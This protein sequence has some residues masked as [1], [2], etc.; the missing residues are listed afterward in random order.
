MALTNL[1]A[2]ANPYG[3]SSDSQD[4]GSKEIECCICINAIGPFQALFISPCSHI[5]HHKCVS[6]MINKSPM[7]QCPLCRQVANLTASISSGSLINLAEALPVM[8]KLHTEIPTA[9][10][11]A[12]AL[13]PVAES[14]RR[15][16]SSMVAQRLSLMSAFFRRPSS[17]NAGSATTPEAT[18][19]GIPRF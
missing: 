3:G 9:T 6:S 8:G 11:L 5:Y 1:L 16:S 12:N 18:P 10:E 14:D 7:F 4:Q 17:S 19:E 13:L 15:K 2:A